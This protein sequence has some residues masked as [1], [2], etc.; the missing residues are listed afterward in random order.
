MCMLKAWFESLLGLVVVILL[1]VA[2]PFVIVITLCY[3]A[4][5]V[6][7]VA[8][9]IFFASMCIFTVYIVAK[10]TGGYKY[11][12]RSHGRKTKGELNAG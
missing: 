6:A 9:L 5:F 11:I 10:A 12:C 2:T 8:G 3:A 1:A 7:G 4:F